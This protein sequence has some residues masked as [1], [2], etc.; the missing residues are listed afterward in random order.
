MKDW[1]IAQPEPR[2]ISQI[3][4][5][6]SISPLLA[7]LLV[8]RNITNPETAKNFLFPE[9]S[10]L[11]DPFLFSQ[12]RVAVD[13]IKQ[14]INHK[15]NILI[16]GDYDADGLTG[17][18]LLYE[19]LRKYTDHVYWYI[20]HR[21]NE[22]YG[23]NS[24]AIQ[25]VK[26]DGIKLII[27]VDCGITASLEAALAKDLGIDLIIS[28]HHTFNNISTF[29]T[30]HAILHA[31]LPESKYPFQSLAGVGV[32][33]KLAQAISATQEKQ[34]TAQLELL[35]YLDLVAIGTICD[36]VPL[37]D[38]NRILTKFGLQTLSKTM[39]PGL[40]ALM[41]VAGI[42]NK[43]MDNF[44]VAFMLGPRL[45]AAG[46]MGQTEIALR[47]LFTQSDSEAE[48]LAKKLDGF[49]KQRQQIEL[50][51]LSEAEDQIQTTCDLMQNQAI[52]LANETWHQ[53]VLGI[54]AGKL[55][56]KYHRPVALFTLNQDEW[57]GSARGIGRNSAE[58]DLMQV[59]SQ[60]QEILLNYGGHWKAA[61]ISI[62]RSRF[63]EFQ[64]RFCD[65]ATEMLAE[66][67]ITPP[68]FI[69]AELPIPKLTPTIIK[70]ELTR[71]E[72][73][74]A[75]NPEPIFMVQNLMLIDQPK[76]MKEKHLKLRLN[77]PENIKITAMGYNW[78]NKY[79]EFP[80]YGQTY[81]IAFYPKLN[82]Y[83]GME[84]IELQIKDLIKQS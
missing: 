48:Y 3:T 15:E 73:Y 12:M 29:P 77:S 78:V 42:G 5:S 41:T 40:R 65:I 4:S 23:L 44:Q 46:R 79:N 14:A 74:G 21:I 39:R 6:L 13:R 83:Q 54:V 75:D 43:K 68:I 7:R 69:D 82:Y 84:S 66:S 17:T 60:C 32:A 28:D 22:G 18:A 31:G 56:E 8:N 36:V 30:A 47:L 27:T 10:M 1:I 63:S 62:S 50:D 70:D 67:K 34:N 37:V 20:P 71:L 64:K 80:T 72:P 49:N 25:Q 55:A 61:G 19:V 45:N 76:L 53:G 58:F 57:L 2:I 33:F 51:I 24:E 11:Y 26:Q 38:E 16:Y 9:L 52:V 35:E 81:K 59:L